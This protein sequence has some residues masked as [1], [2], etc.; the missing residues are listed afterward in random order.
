[1]AVR[2]S[3]KRFRQSRR[4]GQFPC[5]VCGKTHL[6]VEHHINGREVDDADG[7]WNICWLCPDEHDEVHAGN[8]II[9]G[10]FQ[11][12]MGRQ[13]LWHRKGEQPRVNDG[14]TVPLYGQ[15]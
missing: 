12:S 4:S 3:K 10:W 7:N 11:T 8:L 13:L 5:D 15:G 9:E 1:M 2:S 14:V 6:L